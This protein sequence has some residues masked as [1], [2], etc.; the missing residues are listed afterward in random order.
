MPCSCFK[1]LV[2]IYVV[3][4]FP[5]GEVCSRGSPEEG[6]LREEVVQQCTPPA[7]VVLGGIPAATQNVA[8]PPQHA[9]QPVAAALLPPPLVGP[10]AELEQQTADTEAANK[11]QSTTVAWQNCNTKKLEEKPSLDFSTEAVQTHLVSG[12]SGDSQKFSHE[13]SVCETDQIRKEQ[14]L[15]Y[16]CNTEKTSLAHRETDMAE[17]T[18]MDH[19]QDWT[20]S[21]EATG[22]AAVPVEMEMG[23]LVPEKAYL[24]IKSKSGPEELSGTPDTAGESTQIPLRQSISAISSAVKTRDRDHKQPGDME[25]QNVPLKAAI[26]MASSEIFSEPKNVTNTVYG[27][28][29]VEGICSSTNPDEKEGQA[30]SEHHSNS[31]GLSTQDEPLSKVPSPTDNG[32]D[33]PNDTD[34]GSRYLHKCLVQPPLAAVQTQRTTVPHA[35]LPHKTSVSSK[36]PDNAQAT[37][38][39]QLS[40]EHVNCSGAPKP[41][42]VG[43]QTSESEEQGNKNLSLDGD[44]IGSVA[45]TEVLYDISVEE[46]KVPE[47]G[48]CTLDVQASKVTEG[49]HVVVCGPTDVIVKENDC[50][51]NI[52]VTLYPDRQPDGSSLSH[53][54]GCLTSERL[55]SDQPCLFQAST[56]CLIQQGQESIPADRKLS[57]IICVND[58][59]SMP[60]DTSM[61]EKQTESSVTLSGLSTVEVK[62]FIDVGILMQPGMEDTW[63]VVSESSPLLDGQC[64]STEDAEMLDVSTE[65]M[66]QC[67]ESQS[68]VAVYECAVPCFPSEGVKLLL[69]EKEEEDPANKHSFE[70]LTQTLP[71]E[72]ETLSTHPQ[73]VF[74]SQ[75]ASSCPTTIKPLVQLTAVSSSQR[76]ISQSCMQNMGLKPT[77]CSSVESAVTLSESSLIN[78]V[79]PVQKEQIKMTENKPDVSCV[80]LPSGVIDPKLLILKR[81]ETPLLKPPP[82]MLTKISSNQDPPVQSG[83]PSE[84][85]DTVS[86]E[87]LFEN[88][89]V[90]EGTAIPPEKEALAPPSSSHP[91]STPDI[92]SSFLKD[93]SK[94]EA[95]IESDYSHGH[96]EQ[97]PQCEHLSKSASTPSHSHSLPILPQTSGSAWRSMCSA[98]TAQDQSE[99]CPTNRPCQDS[100][101]LGGELEVEE[102]HSPVQH[103]AV[104]KDAHDNTPGRLDASI[105]E[106]SDGEADSSMEAQTDDSIIMPSSAQNK[107]RP[108]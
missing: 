11:E 3:V 63:L 103:L 4:F 23:H 106:S 35:T 36:Q 46:P 85:L 44:L 43:N 54:D 80:S 58:G 42:L 1:N 40:P 78:T 13:L 74:A 81:G 97:I 72:L 49:S 34:E 26:I 94:K 21:T 18:G 76:E 22:D 27:S 95:L 48:M 59:F 79:S 25:Y 82:S 69:P 28:T 87:C 101:L 5:L 98:I 107:V 12:A 7:V 99:Q 102:Q 53:T 9:L 37:K 15:H 30:Y 93:E 57:Q 92:T 2:Y 31:G 71:G 14:D 17:S 38:E 66:V 47:D 77:V 10:A 19:C 50:A 105:G 29:K 88:D 52:Q 64:E 108:T 20:P 39:N 16:G 55:D 41:V 104:A 91:N 73:N 45:V 24:G 6:R 32:N 51:N 89:S 96:G 83:T 86:V 84:R 65:A 33:T 90:Y 62:N 8:G 75:N 70:P 100:M 61:D 67:S 60:G 68:S 56:D